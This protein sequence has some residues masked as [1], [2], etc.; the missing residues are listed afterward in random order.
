MVLWRCHDGTM[1]ML[2]WYYGDVTMVLWRCHGGTMSMLRWY[3]GDVT[4]VL[5]YVTMVLCDMLR[6]YYAV[7]RWHYGAIKRVPWLCMV[8]WYYGDGAIAMI[9]CYD[10][11]NDVMLPLY[12]RL[13]T[14][15]S[16]YYR[17]RSIGVD[18]T[19]KM[20]LSGFHIIT[21]K[22]IKYDIETDIIVIYTYN[23]LS[24]PVEEISIIHY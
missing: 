3:Y 11:D 6:C 17:H 16:L 7:S 19:V 23:F 9:R 24:F 1:A 21:I 18:M 13:C 20:V 12:H 8:R 15:V 2:H 5:C 10:G 4:M 14:I 22:K